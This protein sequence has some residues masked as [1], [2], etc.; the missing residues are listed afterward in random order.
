MKTLKKNEQ[1]CSCKNHIQEGTTNEKRSERLS[2]AL[3]AFF[4]KR[5]QQKLTCEQLTLRDF[6]DL[7]KACSDINNIVTLKVT[8]KFV[9]FLKARNLIDTK[10]MSDIEGLIEK[11]SPNS[12]GYDVEF[13][14]GTK[15]IV[16]EVK[17]NIPVKGTR[18][19]AAQKKGIYKDVINLWAG[20]TKSGLTDKELKEF[21]KFLVLLKTDSI[22]EAVEQL[23]R[24]VNDVG[25]GKKS[26]S[27]SMSLQMDGKTAAKLKGINVTLLDENTLNTFNTGTI[28]VV[29]IDVD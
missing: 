5:S 9:S 1:D 23:L 20:K 17:C 29:I 28:Y 26:P 11:K 2:K 27:K 22:S 10:Q 24:E 25:M 6:I 18:F 13:V 14:K 19:G 8:L 16:A 3:N 7:K 12:N 21:Y 15:K 4:E